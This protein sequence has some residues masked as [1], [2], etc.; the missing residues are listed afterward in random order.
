MFTFSVWFLGLVEFAALS[1]ITWFCLEGLFKD[2][3]E[4]PFSGNSDYLHRMVWALICTLYAWENN[5]TL[6]CH[7]PFE[8]QVP[9]PPGQG[10][11]HGTDTHG[12]DTWGKYS[13]FS[14]MQER[15]IADA[16]FS[17][18]DTECVSCPLLRCSVNSWTRGAVNKCTQCNCLNS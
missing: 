13:V 7:S 6:P 12:T 18:W 1:P 2:T 17:A 10:P 16:T 15:G 5:S 8:E 14:R 9:V 3:L 4:Q 11:I